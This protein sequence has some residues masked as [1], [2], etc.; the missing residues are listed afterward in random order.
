VRLAVLLLAGLASGCGARLPGPARELPEPAAREADSGALRARGANL[1]EVRGCVACHTIGSGVRVGPD[2]SAVAG[3]RE[4]DWIAAM[5][6]RPDSMLER[7]PLAREVGEA[8]PATMPRLG[9]GTEDA[10]ALAA[11]LA[12]PSTPAS[13][14]V[15]AAGEGPGCPGRH[16]RQ[17]R[18]RRGSPHGCTTI[19][20]TGGSAFVPTDGVPPRP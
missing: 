8:Y 19:D 12:D 3:R 4:P 2:L 7:D 20:P 10:I 1:F 14:G 6:R 15:E 18:A 13:T 5:I 11:F 17:V 16:G 9:I